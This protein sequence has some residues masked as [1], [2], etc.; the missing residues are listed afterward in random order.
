MLQARRL[1]VQFPMRSLNC[2]YLPVP[3]SGA[4]ALGLAQRLTDLNAKN[5]PAA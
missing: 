3:S 2:F 4:T 1:E 5:I